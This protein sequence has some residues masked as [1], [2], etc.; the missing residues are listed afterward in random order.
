MQEWTQEPPLLITRGKGPYLYDISG[1]RYLDGTSSIWVNIHGHRHSDIDQAIRKQLNQVAHST[2]LGLS[3]PP[4]ILLARELVRVA[5][6]GLTRVFYSDDGSTALEVAL[7]MAIQYWR[8][9]HDPQ[10]KK[11]TFIHLSLAYHGDTVGGMSLSGVKLFAKPFRSL[12]FPTRSI[13]PPYCY[14]CPLNLTFPS[15]QMACIDP[16]EQLLQTQHQYH[17]GRS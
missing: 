8:Q 2:L 11:R 12:L 9:C 15:C 13:E 3:N 6:S 4:A 7:K 10:P 17:R 16:L 14:R 5:P 1:R